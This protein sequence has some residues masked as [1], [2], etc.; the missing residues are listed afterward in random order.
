MAQTGEVIGAALCAYLLRRIKRGLRK[1]PVRTRR[2]PR[3]PQVVSRAVRACDLGGRQSSARQGR[4]RRRRALYEP[5]APRSNSLSSLP[6]PPLPPP[7]L[8][9]RTSQR[10]FRRDQPDDVIAIP[11]AEDP[12]RKQ[13]APRRSWKWAMVTTG[14]GGRRRGVGG[15]LHLWALRKG[16]FVGSEV[17]CSWTVCRGGGC[18]MCDVFM[19]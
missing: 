9:S 17:M 13:Y 18:A 12:Y 4:F 10:D 19:G 5:H 3:S 16:C 8:V 6:P 7:P 14:V 2:S 11:S 1:P 15:G